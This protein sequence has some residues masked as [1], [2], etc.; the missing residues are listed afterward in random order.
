[1][2]LAE[3][4]RTAARAARLAGKRIA[5]IGG[6]T[7]SYNVLSGLKNTPCSITAVVAMTDSGGSSGRLRDEFGHLPPGDVRQCL[8]ALSQDDHAGMILR[9]LFNYR[10]DKGSGLDGHSFGNLFLTALTEITGSTDAAILEAGRLLN[11]KGQVLPVTLTNASLGA[12]LENGREIVGEANL[13]HRTIDPDVPIDYVF[14]R[15][16]AFVYQETA[17][18]LEA[19]D[20]IVI[21][22]GDLY[23]SVIANLVVDGVT[24][25]IRRSRARKILV[26]NL[27]TKHGES[28]GFKASDFVR[29]VSSYLGFQN[30][31]DCLIVNSAPLPEKVL[32][33]YAPEG[34]FPVE[35]DEAECERLVPHTVAGDF[36]AIGQF[37]RH[38][39]QRLAEAILNVVD[40]QGAPW[41]QDGEP[42]Q[43]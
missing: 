21:G 12:R 38:D 40:A 32:Q 13:D 39:S 19:A 14:L 30:A 34:S 31:L 3:S 36:L 37:V 20:A 43:D 9:Q 10:F 7:G 24:A 35:F 41:A 18:T 1:M 25:A 4:E 27:M 17:R 42:G 15:P 28:D 33:R 6:G 26:C 11:I 29:E 16:T 2:A 5:V 8:L 22:P 23:T